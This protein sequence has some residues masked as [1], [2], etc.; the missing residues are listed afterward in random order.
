[1][2]EILSQSK[3]PVALALGFFDSL[4]IVHRRIISN[5][6]DYAKKNGCSS[7]VFTFKD[8]GI[9]SLKGDM[10]YLYKERK[11]LLEHLSV[12]YVVPFVFSECETLDKLE[13]LD[14]ITTLVEVKAI[15][16][17]YDFTFGYKGQGEVEFLKKYCDKKGIQLFVADKETA[18]N[19]KISSSMIKKFLL[20]GEIKKANELLVKPYSITSTV[21]KGR[22]EGS[23]FGFPTANILINKNKMLIKEGV[24]GTFTIIDG[25]KYVSVTSVGVKPTFNDM[26]VSVETLIKDFSGN[27]YNKE[28]TIEFSK[29]IRD[30]YK[31]E[32]KEMLK[33]QIDKDLK[34]EKSL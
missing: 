27:I 10:I 30:I 1:M 16:C 32:S 3:I 14:K 23:L 24:Y 9:C 5:A 31:F 20:A 22:G 7:A 28:I 29:Y 15:F 4:H 11:K 6:V 2:K 18:Y 21:I 19:E 8:D 34:W 25:K 33:Q 12:D 17:G 13:F 26:S